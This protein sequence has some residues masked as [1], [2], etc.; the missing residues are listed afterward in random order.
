MLVWGDGGGYDDD[1]GL[2]GVMM[3]EN[4]ITGML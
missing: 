2:G 4:I 1:S 3:V